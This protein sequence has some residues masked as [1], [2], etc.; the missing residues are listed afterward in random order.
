ME[1]LRRAGLFHFQSGPGQLSLLANGRRVGAG[2]HPPVR[3][4]DYS[5]AWKWC[6]STWSVTFVPSWVPSSM[7]AP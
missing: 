5:M 3:E 1:K 7:A 6:A 2:A 4:P